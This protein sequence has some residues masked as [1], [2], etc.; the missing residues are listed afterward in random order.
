MKLELRSYLLIPNGEFALSLLIGLRKSLK[1]LNR[2]RLLNRNTELDIR[3]GVLVSR[4]N[5]LVKSR[6]YQNSN[7]H[8]PWYHQAKQPASH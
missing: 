1:L 5:P 6:V 7:I 3:L 2:L 8:R 4:L